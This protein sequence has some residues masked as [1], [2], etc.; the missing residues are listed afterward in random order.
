MKSNNWNTKTVVFSALGM[1]LV[2]VATMF[3]KIPNPYQG[4]FNLGD[5]FILAFAAVLNPAAA[6]LVG[7]VGSALADL[8]GGYF[9]YILPTLIIK[10]LEGFMV[11]WSI[12]KISK[13]AFIPAIFIA[14]GWMVTGYF[15]AGW[16]LLGS[17]ATAA[18]DIPGNLAQAAAG[19]VVCLLCRPLL[20]K[21]N[22]VL[23]LDTENK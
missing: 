19:I 21:L 3:I 18:L 15:L 16:I 9:F 11:S 2:Y 6:F 12:H 4:Y 17:A 13:K 5:G 7:G 1:A 10:G 8:S 23:H 22:Q 20:N 14:S